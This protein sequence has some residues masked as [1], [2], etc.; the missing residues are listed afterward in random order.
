MAMK[1]SHLKLSVIIPM[2]N[3]ESYIVRCL[4]SVLDSLIESG[5]LYE[6]ICIDDGSSDRT[7]QKAE[8]CKTECVKLIKTPNRGVGAARNIGLVFATGDWVAFVDGDDQVAKN[9]FP[10]AYSI[11]C[12]NPVADIVHMHPLVSVCDELSSRSAYCKWQ[13]VSE[14]RKNSLAPVRR[15]KVFEDERATIFAHRLFAKHGWPVM[16]FVRRDFI[17]PTLFPEELRIKEDVVFFI[18]LATRV[19]S[20][21]LAEYPGY[22]YTRREGSAVMRK[23][24]DDD[25]LKFSKSLIALGKKH[26]TEIIWRAISSAMGYDFIQWVAERDSAAKYNPEVCELRSAWKDALSS[27]RLRLSVMH[28]WWRIAI[29]HWLNTGDLCWAHKIRRIREWT[30]RLI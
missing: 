23:R 29:C 9:W 21:V 25:S 1:E 2:Y 8:I 19:K 6:V 22:F 5:W 18:D 30:G 24:S 12:D 17:R 28:W 3:V 14:A 13:S 27:G 16:N 4:T 15:V 26:D 11:V 7:L 20:L 10:N